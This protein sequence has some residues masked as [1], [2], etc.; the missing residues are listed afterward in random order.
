MGI[1]FGVAAV[2]GMYLS[3][4]SALSSFNRAVDFLRGKATHL[5]ERPAGTMDENLLT[6]IMADPAVDHFSPVIDRRIRIE[7]GSMV[8]LLGIDTF[9]DRDIRPEL[10]KTEY[11]DGKDRERGNL[12]S[13]LFDD[14]AIIIDRNLAAEL[15]LNQG[16]LLQTS[17]G[18][19][20]VI[21]VVP[22]P[23]GEPLILMDIAHVQQLYGL[24]G[25]IDRVDLV[26]NDEISFRSRWDR[27]FKVES[28]RQRRE[29]LTGLLQAFRLNLQA[30]S[31]LAL[32]VGVFLI[33]NTAM[34]T[35]V[36]RRRDAG[37][38]M[39]I[40]A[41]RYEIVTAFLA[42]ILCLGSI[43]GILGG[44]LGYGLSRFLTG[45]VGDSIS[46]V[47]FFLR[48]APLP[49]SF[50]YLGLGLLIGCGAGI[51][52]SIQPMLELIRTEPA[53][54]LRGRT[55]FRGGLRKILPTA[56]TGA[57]IAA[58][59]MAV[60]F[61]SF[62]HV[63]IGFAGTFI[64]LL[65]IS[66]T[67]GL[68]IFLS[69]PLF[70]WFFVFT[71]NLPGKMA[72]AHI[73]HNLNRTSV[74]VAAFMIAL[75][76]SIGL[77]SMINSFRESLTWWLN[78]QLRGELYISTRGD[79]DVPVDFLEELLR[80]PEIGGIDVYRNVQ[81][82]YNGLPAF[83][84]SINASVLQ[85]YARFGW[86]TG[87]DENWEPVK[88]GAII[89]SESFSRRF[90]VNRGDAVELKGPRGPVSF[91]V[92]AVFYDYT[93]E[94]GVIMMDRST[95]INVFNDNA[96]NSL[97]IFFDSGADR[98]KVMKKIKSMTQERN[99][100]IQ[101]GKELHDMVLEVFDNT[102]AVT[103]SMRIL[104]VVIALFGIAGALMTLF[105]ER[106]R[107]FGI[108][109]ALG[110]S[111][112]QIASMTLYEGLCMGLIS[113]AMSTG[114]GTVLAIILIKVINLRSFNWTIFY[115]FSL[116]PYILAGATTIIASTGASLYPL[117][118]VYRTYPQIQIREE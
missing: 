45:L 33:Y 93:S 23:S 72:S 67:S 79:V 70:K 32:F 104:A 66:L 13:F 69:A 64:F 7:D 115:H 38:L 87:G 12:F 2:V 95:Y 56:A 118:K 68:A 16:S 24:R 22:N 47:Y 71:G 17:M 108:Y 27:G 116:D 44:L 76:L 31:L 26:L 105:V 4:H 8:R 112:G 20:K 43:G 14:N 100:P 36:S 92:A 46:N 89:I 58:A 62:L 65:G 77:G 83:I 114:V 52:G 101:T 30:L 106:Q 19:L 84:T 11:I 21:A 102:F 59:G 97:G 10:A 88:R 75:S 81:I 29:A 54:A 111:T 18:P 74:A 103:K 63:Y 55:S 113:F 109:R 1:A 9:L 61:L 117:W 37:I 15:G 40:G 86:V 35:V 28:N 39:S 3:A 34:F 49:W 110:F 98:D 91:D 57:A 80:L 99:L 51:L 6:D 48:P 73:R 60:L 42:E 94:H 50:Q 5:L 107:E 41:K 53:R 85:K 78:S 96:I 82:T 25:H 90:K